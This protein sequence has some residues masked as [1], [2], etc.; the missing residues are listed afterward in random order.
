MIREEEIDWNMLFNVLELEMPIKAEDYPIVVQIFDTSNAIVLEVT[1]EQA[2]A[3]LKRILPP[4][5]YRYTI[6]KN[7]KCIY[8]T[9][10]MYFHHF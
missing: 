8:S 1:F 4:G 6:I 9:S 3:I 5:R 10:Y 2:P 7:G